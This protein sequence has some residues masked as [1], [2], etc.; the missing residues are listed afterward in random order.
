MAYVNS[1]YCGTLLYLEITMYT[2]GHNSFKILQ[3][4]VKPFHKYAESV[5]YIRVNT[6]IVKRKNNM[7]I[8]MQQL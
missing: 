4:N 6:S 1:R 2:S 5:T 7:N 3:I 8:S